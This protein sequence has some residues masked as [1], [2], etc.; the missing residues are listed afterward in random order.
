MANF[1]TARDGL[2]DAF[3]GL[4]FVVYDYTPPVVSTPAAFIFPDD[5]YIDFTTI[6]TVTK[7]TLRFRL[8][9]AVANNDNQAALGNLETVICALATHLPQGARVSAFGAPSITQVGPTSL[10][11]SETSVEITTSIS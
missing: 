3:D 5:P 11:V 10:L 1:A 8:T 6:G 9:A 2:M 4:G 7:A